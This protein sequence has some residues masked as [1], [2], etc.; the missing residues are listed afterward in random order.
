M[1]GNQSYLSNS[2]IETS[3]NA[4]YTSSDCSMYNTDDEAFPEPIP[5]NLSP[6]PDQNVPSGQP[7]IFD[8]N[9]KNDLISPLPL[10]LLFNSRSVYNKS[11]NLNEM[12]NQIGPDL[13]LISESWERERKRLSS[14]LSKQFKSFSYYRKNKSPGGGCAIVFNENRFLVEELEVEAPDGV[15][16]VWAL[17]K[18]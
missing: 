15:E 5:A 17:L 4:S 3:D 10:C 16:C 13:C 9:Q 7:I 14:I 11:D 18:T 8:V 1:D 12:L 2:S 6:A